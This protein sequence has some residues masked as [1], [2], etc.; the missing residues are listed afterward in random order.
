M[1]SKIHQVHTDHYAVYGVRKVHAE[2][3]RK[4]HRVARCTVQRLMKRA[5]LRGISRAKGSRTIVGSTGPDNLPE[6]V[7]RVL[8]AVSPYQ[9]KPSASSF[10]TPQR[11]ELPGL[12]AQ[13]VLPPHIDLSK[14]RDLRR[15]SDKPSQSLAQ[16]EMSAPGSLAHQRPPGQTNP[17]R[18]RCSPIKGSGL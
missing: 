6:L 3:N 15:V 14:R 7:E 8:T 18:N 5:G 17:C 9:Q 16:Q 2:L 11:E 10:W 4:G 1:T 12:A 13:R